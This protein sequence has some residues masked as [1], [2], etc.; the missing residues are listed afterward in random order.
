MGGGTTFGKHLVKDL[1]LEESC[2]KNTTPGVM[3]RYNC[4]RPNTGRTHWLFS[5]FTTGWRCGLHP[6]WTSLHSCVN[7][8]YANTEGKEYSN[9][10]Y[11]TFLRE[12]ISRF[13]SEWK[14]Q[15]RSATW[16]KE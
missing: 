9:Y 6:D 5:R 10:H 2:V 11:F 14:H 16:A 13:L 8:Y 1:E 12:P 3:K 7:N 15:Q 4:F